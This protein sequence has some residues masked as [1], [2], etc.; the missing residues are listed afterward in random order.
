MKSLLT[1]PNLKSKNFPIF[2]F[3]WGPLVMVL[4]RQVWNGI[5]TVQMLKSNCSRAKAKK[6]SREMWLFTLNIFKLFCASCNKLFK[7]KCILCLF[8]GK[9]KIQY[10]VTWGFF[11]TAFRCSHPC[12][13]DA[14]ESELGTRSEH[15]HKAVPH[16][17]VTAKIKWLFA[18]RIQIWGNSS[19]VSC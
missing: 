8:L 2:Y 12:L 15:T 6:A 11:F 14:T 17:E 16:A 1:C 9:K 19:L 13:E 3:Q 10:S 4:I 7:A 18:I 5:L